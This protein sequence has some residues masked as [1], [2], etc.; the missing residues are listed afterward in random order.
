MAIHT[1]KKIHTY[2]LTHIH[3]KQNLRETCILKGEREAIRDFQKSDVWSC[4]MVK[5]ITEKKRA[6]YLI[7]V[8]MIFLTMNVKM[9]E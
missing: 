6:K 2:T 3:K 4:M 8:K 5:K 1:H 7:F 9:F